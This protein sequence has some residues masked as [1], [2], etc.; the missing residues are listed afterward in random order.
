[1]KV[2]FVYPGYI[3]REVPL[4]VMYI[5]AA[6]EKAGHK[7]RLFHF[8][9]YRKLT[10]AQ[11]VTER[12]EEGFLAMM[13]EFKP[14]LVAFSVMV[15]DYNITKHLSWLVRDRYKLPVVWGGIQPI[16]EPD[17]SIN[18][19]EVDY[20]C[21]GEGEKVFPEFLDRLQRGTGSMEVTGIWGK[22]A[23]G[24]VYR[25]DRPDLIENLDEVPFPNRDL[26][27]PEYYRAELTGTNILTARGCPFPC[28]FCQNKAL[29]EIYKD[30]GK[31]IRYRSLDNVF[32]EMEEVIE[33]YGAPSFY[34]SDEM[35]T[36]DKRRAM[37]FC[38]EYKK[39]INKP[40]MVQTRADYMDEELARAL[41]EAGCTMVNMAIESGN[42]HIRNKVLKKS[43]P[44]EK[45]MHAYK[46]MSD[47][48]MMSSSF[49][50]IGVPGET[51]DTIWDTIDINR[52]LKPDRIL[53]SI[54][55]PLP[56]TELGDY[57]ERTKL[58]TEDV[59]ETT[60]YY[61]QVTIRNSNLSART[62]IGYQGFFDWFVL[63]P[64]KFHG[65]VHV[66]RVI[67]QNIVTP[68]IPKNPIKRKLREMIV[69]TVY[70]MKAYLPQKKFHAKTR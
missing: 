22:D 28:S 4:N 3:V 14:D 30:K 60:N 46:L 55:M 43:I 66:L 57:C 47:Y 19:P 69:E 10:W 58:I 50:M 54:F 13:N 15:Q 2:L 38:Q 11:D 39:R 40:F 9:P 70:Q 33:K 5:S 44:T 64:R 48:G 65:L 26:L 59:A 24:N 31:F 7:S 16:L 6:I 49:N 62:L 17:R 68:R 21:T 41:S 37:D 1:M 34:F 8:S 23:V 51:V 20:I 67:Y 29:I 45:I 53:C 36:L 35:F 63:L 25:N 12:I 52:K 61:S 27:G 32:R 42:E 18:E 56:G